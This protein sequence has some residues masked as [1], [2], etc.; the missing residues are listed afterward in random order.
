MFHL[1]LDLYYPTFSLASGVIEEHR[2]RLVPD[3]MKVLSCIK[4]SKFANTHLQ[5]SVEQETRELEAEHEN[6]YLDD[7]EAVAATQIDGGGGE[8]SCW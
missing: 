7:P 4:D 8:L 6:V 1:K 5:Y 3:M 2:R